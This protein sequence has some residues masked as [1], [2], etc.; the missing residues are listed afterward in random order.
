MNTGLAPF[1]MCSADFSAKFKHGKIT[2]RQLY[3]TSTSANSVL[4]A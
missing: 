3:I 1:F 2:S 4:V